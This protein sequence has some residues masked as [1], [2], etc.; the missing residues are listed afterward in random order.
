MKLTTK[1]PS[2]IVLPISAFS[3]SAAEELKVDALSIVAF[4]LVAIPP[5]RR[6]ALLDVLVGMVP[7]I[8]LPVA[9]LFQRN[10]LTVVSARELGLAVTLRIS[11]IMFNK[12]AAFIL[13]YFD[14]YNRF[15]PECSLKNRN[16]CALLHNQLCFYFLFTIESWFVEKLRSKGQ[17][18]N[19]ASVEK[20]PTE[21]R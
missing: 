21:I 19:Y 12:K 11:W 15:N 7:T 2:R 9:L 20:C 3:F 17:R 13:K 16:W 5:A 4:E 1:L 10:A 6:T 14:T 8:E 18:E